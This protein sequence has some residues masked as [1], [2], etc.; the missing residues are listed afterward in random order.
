MSPEVHMCYSLY[1]SLSPFSF[2][3]IAYR[4]N[5][6]SIS[7]NSHSINIRGYSLKKK[8]KEYR[9]KYR[10]ETIGKS[11]MNFDQRHLLEFINKHI[12][13]E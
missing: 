5:S 8:I 3:Y 7:H 2:K 12:S 6:E 1:A 9:D 4:F 13:W 11:W 10:H